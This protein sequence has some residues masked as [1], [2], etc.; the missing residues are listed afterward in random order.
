MRP[1]IISNS[2]HIVGAICLLK[3]AIQ[4]PAFNGITI[5]RS[6]LKEISFAMSIEEFLSVCMLIVI[7]CYKGISYS[8]ELFYIYKI[9]NDC[10]KDELYSLDDVCIKIDTYPISNCLKKKLKSHYVLPD[11]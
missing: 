8:I 1:S 6:G 4:Q 10:L 11:Y 2:L 9:E 3:N 7:L 5:I